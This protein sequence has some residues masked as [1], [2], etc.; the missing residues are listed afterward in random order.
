MFFL[1]VGGALRSDLRG[2]SVFVGGE[3]AVLVFAFGY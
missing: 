2:L 3:I 1:N